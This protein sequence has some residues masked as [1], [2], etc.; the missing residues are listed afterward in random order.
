MDLEDIRKL[1]AAAERKAAELTGPDRE[2]WQTM[3]EQWSVLARLRERLS[4]S[5]IKPARLGLGRRP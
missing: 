3:A 1:H 4:R 2:A 5:D